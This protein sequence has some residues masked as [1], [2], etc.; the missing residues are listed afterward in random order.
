MKRGLKIV[1]LVLL[2]AS[3]LLGQGVQPLELTIPTSPQA[4]AFKQYGE[5]SINYS[6][7]VPDISIPLYEINHRNYK[8]PLILKYYPSPIKPGYNYDVYG[9]GWGLSV[10]SSIS[11]SIEFCPDELK[12]FSIEQDLLDDLY[13]PANSSTPIDLTNYNFAHDKFNGVLPNG[14]SFDF[15]IEK[16]DGILEYTTSNGRQLKITCNYDY[17]NI[18]SFTII[19]ED[20]VKYTFDGSDIPCIIPFNKY[21]NRFISWQ[22]T[23]IDL[24]NTGE[25]II[26]SYDYL[27]QGPLTCPE[28]EISVYRTHHI[29]STESA[30]GIINTANS[31]TYSFRMKLLTSV[32]YGNT[33]ISFIYQNPNSTSN[34]T[35]TYNYVNKIEIKNGSTLI[36]EIVLEKDIKSILNNCSSNI[37]LAKLKKI[38]IKGFDTADST[39][40]YSCDYSSINGF[41]GTDHWGNLNNSGTSYEVAN[42]N[43]FVGFDVE[44]Y[45]ALN[46]TIAS[47]V[48]KTDQDLCPYD[49]VKLASRNYDFR[50]PS[51]PES[52]GVLSKLTFPTG[53]YTDFKFENHEFLTSTDANG[54]FILNRDNRRKVNAG[55]FRIR[56][57]TNYSRTGSVAKIMSFKYGKT[58]G[59]LYGPTYSNANQHTGLGEVV[60]DPNILTYMSYTRYSSGMTLPSIKYMVLGL[61]ESGEQIPFPNPF[62]DNL[63]YKWECTFS[64]SNFR[65]I[66]NGRPPVL[67]SQVTVY[68]GDIEAGSNYSPE[69]TTGKTVYKYNWTDHGTDLLG[70]ESDDMFM[71]EPYYYGHTI[72]YNPK[73]YRYNQLLE[74]LDYKYDPQIVDPKDSKYVMVKKE[75]F[76]WTNYYYTIYNKTYNHA[77]PNDYYPKYCRVYE[78][79]VPQ[80]IVLGI[81]KLISKNTDIYT[82]EGRVYSNGEGYS[83]NTRD[84]LITK[85][86]IDSQKRRIESRFFYPEVASNGATPTIIQKMLAK[87]IITP[88]IKATTSVD[89]IITNGFKVDYNEFTVGTKKILMPAQVFELEVKPSG[90][91][92][93]LKEEIKS[94]STN[95]NPLEY[96]STNGNPSSY[97]WGYNDRYLVVIADNMNN[98]TLMNHI[99][100]SLPQG[101][102]TLESLLSSISTLP[103]VNWTQFNNNLRNSVASDKTMI[104]TY[105]YKPFIGMTSQTDPNG[106]TT[107]YE[108]DD[109]GRLKYIKD[110]DENI[111]QKNEYHYTE[112]TGN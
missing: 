77:Y 68:H 96:V 20:G 43:F 106:I 97:V 53:G 69:N 18:Y 102:T 41:T 4:E 46:T 22:L 44:Y 13:Y 27:I 54:N 61:S 19:D 89:G 92:Y 84:Q 62:F 9:H 57:I 33:N 66:L 108:Y 45:N 63:Q 48:L 60:V 12:D 30:A 110:H 23:R 16:I 52:H 49:K 71:E 26:F 2:I 70:N 31:A 55:G 47:S 83:Y 107:Y 51:S 101:F 72:V 93:I 112:G 74:Q 15:S 58:Y 88:V 87:N 59:E 7:G 8:L 85:T 6:T 86:T 100:A 17:A 80:P 14:T 29:Q 11:R 76:G 103:N 38:L 32:H 3:N 95:G 56:K 64:A 105:T 25:P 94:Y 28:P 78:Y 50:N 40:V 35:T 39:L 65:K 67:Y 111:L 24:P 21:S 73:D 99:T 1:M 36:R 79:L 109:F 34:L 10:H 90:N 37:K 98:A 91:E 75:T 104:T 82:S 81:S 42:F 5:Y